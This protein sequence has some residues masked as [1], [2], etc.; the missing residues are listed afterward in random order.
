M[1]YRKL[2]DELNRYGYK[3]NE[4]RE[5]VY[6]EEKIQ[7]AEFY[8]MCPRAQGE[9]PQPE[10]GYIRESYDLSSSCK[11]CGSGMKQKTPFFL[12]SIPK[13]GNNDIISMLW[14]YEFLITERLKKIIH[15]E[16][17]SVVDF[18]PLLKYDNHKSPENIKR[19]Y[20][21]YISNILPPMSKQTVF[22]KVQLPK[23]ANPCVCGKIGF[24]IP[25]QLIYER[26][27]FLNSK[28]FNKSYEWLGGGFDTSQLVI[29]NKNVFNAFNEFK[30]QGVKFEPI[31]IRN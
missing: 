15:E 22:P 23:G 12:K 14:T 26:E 16:H 5:A 2:I 4:T 18:Y 27:S 7:S 17:L 20:Q 6:S 31:I 1:K 30:I 21:L 29:V 8:Y 13:F 24:N 3:Y 19:Y 9:D 28:D 25:L 10:D 11:E